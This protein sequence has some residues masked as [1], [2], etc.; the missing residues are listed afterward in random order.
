M[1]VLVTYDI[2]DDRRR[3]DVAV[4]LSGYG[5]R[6]QLSVFE[7]ECR[8]SDELRDLRARL[9]DIID[10]LEDQISLA[11]R[12]SQQATRLITEANAEW[13]RR[14]GREVEF[15]VPAMITRPVHGRREV[16]R[17]LDIVCDRGE[18]L[19]L[20]VIE[21]DRGN[22][23]WSLQKLVAEAEAGNLA[24]WV[25]WKGRHPIDVPE[26]VGLVDTMHTISCATATDRSWI[27]GPTPPDETNAA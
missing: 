16:R 18:D 19:P 25:R 22:K 2:T 7:C 3:E 27:G 17:R 20:I 10:P 8:D 1:I 26:Q 21:V 4:L 11:G 6:V 9:R 15:E 12:S 23:R 24:I 14:Q 13:A 5:P